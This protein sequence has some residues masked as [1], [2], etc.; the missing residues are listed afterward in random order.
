MTST[1]ASMGLAFL[2]SASFNP[3]DYYSGP[4]CG[5]LLFAY[6]LV[7]D[8]QP[9]KIVEL[10]SHRGQSYFAF[11]KAVADAG[12]ATKT[13]AIDTWQGDPHA[14]F[15]EESIYQKFSATNEQLFKSFSTMLRCTF[16]EALSHF[17]ETSVDLLHIDGLHTY[18]AVRH[19]FETWRSKLTRPAIVLF[20]DIAVREKDFGVWKFW[21]EIKSQYTSFEF[22]HSNGLGVLLLGSPDQFFSQNGLV[23]ALFD[24]A[25]HANIKRVYAS[26]SALFDRA[27]LLPALQSECDAQA[28]RLRH[29]KRELRFCRRFSLAYLL[30]RLV[31][32]L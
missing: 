21:M 7:C 31:K 4:W 28:A 10:G 1:T 27:H 29:M 25:Q 2:K 9:R 8:F 11:C 12:L 26:I 24:D 22:E 20:H 23:K 19:D 14:G 13:Y 32:S 16:D 17:D 18:D 3:I 15:Y 30:R 6:D 5:H